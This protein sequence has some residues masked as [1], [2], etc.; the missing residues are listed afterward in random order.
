MTKTNTMPKKTLAELLLFISENE[1]FSSVEKKLGGSVSVQEVRFALRELAV[2]IA[3]EADS[4]CE[5]VD[6]ARD[7]TELSDATKKILSILSPHEEK[8][9]F[10][11]FGLAKE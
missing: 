3:K 2:E 6:A 10:D 5:N 1:T 11:A 7:A 8:T 9:L 4:A